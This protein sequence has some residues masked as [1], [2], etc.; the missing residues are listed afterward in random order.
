MGNINSVD[1]AQLEKVMAQGVEGW[2][3]GGE[4]DKVLVTPTPKVALNQGTAK[5]KQQTSTAG[6]L[7]PE[8]VEKMRQYQRADANK[9]PLR[10]VQTQVLQQAQERVHAQARVEEAQAG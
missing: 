2:S 3:S 1:V 6:Q 8:E 10:R 5:G 7:T 4:Q 9:E